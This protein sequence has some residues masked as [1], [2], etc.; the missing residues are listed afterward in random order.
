MENSLKELVALT[1][2]YHT[3]LSELTDEEA[4]LQV[5]GKWSPDEHIIHLILSLSPILK[6]LKLP[7]FQLKLM[8]GSRK[9]DAYQ[10]TDVKALYE[11]ALSEGL[12]A[13]KDYVPKENKFATRQELYDSWLKKT[14]G[15][16]HYLNK[17]N[18]N[19]LDK[20]VLPHPALGKLSITELT[21]FTLIHTR[22]HLSKIK[23]KTF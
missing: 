6:A 3:L 21:H 16:E 8:F 4:S 20:V 1:S 23:Q 2:E 22:I 5:D 18:Q 15:F 17:W 11:K 14:K 9:R 7:K 10:Y 13:P 12:K 19:D